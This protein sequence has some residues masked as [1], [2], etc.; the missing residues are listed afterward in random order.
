[1]DEPVVAPAH[2]GDAAAPADTAVPDPADPAGSAAAGRHRRFPTAT[3]GVVCGLLA[4]LPVLAAFLA[5]V[6]DKWGPNLDEAANAWRSWDQL[7]GH[8][9]SVGPIT[10]ATNALDR[11]VYDPGP[12]FYWVLALP[13]RLAPDAGPLVAAALLVL[14]C[15][16]AGCSAARAV[17]GPAAAVVAAVGALVL[18]A[19]LADQMLVMPIWNPYLP[20]LPWGATLLVAVAVAAGRLGWWPLLVALASL[21]VQSH[22]IYAPAVG[23]AVLTPIVGVRA[24]SAV[25][26]RAGRLWLLAGLAVGLVFWLPAVVQQVTGEPGNLGLLVR[27]TVLDDRPSIGLGSG[28]REFGAAVGPRPRWLRTP[29]PWDLTDVSA[30]S[31]L[32]GAVA[33]LAVAAVL[34]LRWSAWSAG[35]RAFGVVALAS[36]V[37]SVVTVAGIARDTML[38]IVYLRYAL[39]PVAMLLVAFLASALVDQLRMRTE[40]HTPAGRSL[41]PRAPAVPT[42][43][44]VV[45]VISLGL[46][47]WTA[48]RTPDVASVLQGDRPRDVQAARAV[49][50]L[51]G[52]P[53]TRDARIEV[54]LPDPGGH[55]GVARQLAVGYQLRTLG[56]TPTI[57]DPEISQLLAPVYTTRPG[58]PLVSLS[59]V[60]PPGARVLGRVE[61]G[62]SPL[63]VAVRP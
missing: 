41:R 15:L 19:T 30:G 7:A 10:Q 1:M 45:A 36:G 46:S 18:T 6:R 3:V 57:A 53:P 12:A 59:A 58:E 60:P 17:G 42:A 32:L 44:G 39:Y 16:I 29:Q 47:V 38:A 54:G 40:R 52:P 27:S 20:L 34:A 28:L 55:D 31:A 62:G 51:L 56:W 2:P 4:S 24:R 35:R 13:T 37:L 8:R 23:L 43:I 33:L 49:R 25:G 61:V 50:A 48:A 63:T 21:V 14:V 26:D 5:L 22:L 9:V 11:S